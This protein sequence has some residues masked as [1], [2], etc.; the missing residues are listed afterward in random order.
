M[1]RI[2]ALAFCALIVSGSLAGCIDDNSSS[3]D[4]QIADD[5][6]ATIDEAADA[7]RRLFHYSASIQDVTWHP[8][9]GQQPPEGAPPCQFGLTM[10]FTR[11]Y[12][13]LQHRITSKV[14]N[15]TKTLTI[16]I[17]T[18][19]ASNIHPKVAALP[20]TESLSPTNLQLSTVY[21]VKVVNRNG[22]RLWTGQ[23]G[24][25]LAP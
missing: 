4:D 24:T 15:S 3:S 6:D 20:Q 5:G 18:F 10:T 1:K 7:A 13:D 23:I 21:S 11:T 17:D 22:R 19:S 12:F 14:N 8:G 16:T 9:C 2:S 25:F